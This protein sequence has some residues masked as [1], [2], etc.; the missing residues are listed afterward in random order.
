MILEMALDLA[1]VRVE[2]DNRR[3]V[4]VVARPL[5][6]EPWRGIAGAPKGH[7]A[8]WIVGGRDPDRAATAL[9]VIATR[10]PRLAAR[11]AWCGYGVGLPQFLA[12]LGIERSDKPAHAQFASRR[13]K[14]HL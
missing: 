13:A 6:A 12:G 4:E 8:F 2:R 5:I 1:V 11:L 7:V 9:V 3:G 10:G 14:D